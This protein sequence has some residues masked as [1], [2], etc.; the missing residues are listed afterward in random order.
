[1]WGVNIQ[2]SISPSDKIGIL[3]S[4]KTL[5]I[6]EPILFHKRETGFLFLTVKLIKVTLLPHQSLV[7]AGKLASK[8]PYPHSRNQSLIDFSMCTKLDLIFIL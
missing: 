8:Y 2:S 3:D 4:P 5:F 6:P 1:M 7:S